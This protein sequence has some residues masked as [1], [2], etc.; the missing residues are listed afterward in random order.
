MGVHRHVALGVLEAGGSSCS[1]AC[2]R[3]RRCWVVHLLPAL[4]AILRC[5]LVHACVHCC[6]HA[7]AWKAALNARSS[8][9][10]PCSLSLGLSIARLR[11]WRCTML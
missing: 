10:M 9:V 5:S 2:N 7:A 4:N 11:C 3:A 8:P 1:R 6:M